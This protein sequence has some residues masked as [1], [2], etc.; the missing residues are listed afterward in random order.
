MIGKRSI[1]VALLETFL[2]STLTFWQVY[3]IK[4]LIDTR[5]SV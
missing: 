5:E 4:S 2:V 1:Y 3:Y